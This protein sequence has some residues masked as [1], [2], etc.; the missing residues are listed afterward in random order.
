MKIQVVKEKRKTISLKVFDSNNAVLKVPRNLGEKTVQNFLESKQNWLKKVETKMLENE[1]FS[2]EFMFDKFIYLNGQ[3]NIMVQ[4]LCLDFELQTQ[5]KKKNIIR[6]FYLS[7]FD[8]LIKLA[9]QI[10]LKTNLQV[11]QVKPTN[12]LRVWGSFNSQKIMKL[13]W[14]LLILPTQLAEYVI[15]HELCHSLH[16]NHS[17]MFWKSVEKYCPNYKKLKKELSCFGFILKSDVL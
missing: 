12:S 15:I 7:H 1:N 14:K 10:S 8:D 9:H 2:K 17:P 11:K 13:N 5:Q 3:K 4:E 6:K 16:M